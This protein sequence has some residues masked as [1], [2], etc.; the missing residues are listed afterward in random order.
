MHVYPA[1][2]YREYLCLFVVCGGP[3]CFSLPF[4]LP[5]HFL[6]RLDMI[7]GQFLVMDSAAPVESVGRRVFYFRADL[8]SLIVAFMFHSPSAHS[9]LRNNMFISFLYFF[10]VLHRWA[11]DGRNQTIFEIRMKSMRE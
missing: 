5:P 10:S 11:L 2:R 8:L 3:F 4:F 7:F 1:E 6:L 9:I